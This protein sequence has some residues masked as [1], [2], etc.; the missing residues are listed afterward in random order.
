MQDAIDDEQ[1]DFPYNCD[2]S[3]AFSIVGMNDGEID[4]VAL[5]FARA[6]RA[7]KL[8][9]ISE[10]D[11]IGIRLIATG[12]ASGARAMRESLRSDVVSLVVDLLDEIDKLD[13]PDYYGR[14]PF[15]LSLL[16]SEVRYALENV[17]NA[18][19]PVV[20]RMPRRVHACSRRAKC[21]KQKKPT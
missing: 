2:P 21:T 8:L 20:Q 5:E 13:D 18:K 4:A 19:P 15:T 12:F 14:D 11:T 10:F 1:D 17:P 9:E 16:A 3:P 6:N 7:C